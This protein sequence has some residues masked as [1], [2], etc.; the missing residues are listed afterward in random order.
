MYLTEIN[1]PLLAFWLTVFVDLI[2]A[3]PELA[4][5]LNSQVPPVAYVSQ[6]YNFVFSA[7]TFTS[8]APQISYTITHGP[9]WLDLDGPSRLIQGVPDSSDVGTTTLQLVASDP[10]GDLSA[11]ITLIV[12][13]SPTLTLG[14]PLLPQLEESGLIS[15]PSSLLAQPQ[16]PFHVSF[17]TQTFTGATPETRYYA[18]SAGNAPLPP[19]VHFDEDQLEFSGITPALVSSLAGSQTYGLRLIA[20]NVPGFAELAIDFQLVISRRILAFSAAT[21]IANIS[22]GT[23]FQTL[24][25]RPLI[26]LNGA[27]VT[28]DQIDS[29]DVDVPAWAELDR[30]GLSLSGTPDDSVSTTIT[31]T[32]TDIYHDVANA[33]IFL[34]N[35][36]SSSVSLGVIG[37]VN[38]TAGEYFS[39][40]WTSPTYSPWVRAVAILGNASA[41][42]DFNAQTWALSGSVPRDLPG[43]TLSVSITFANASTNATGDVII[44]VLQKPFATAT[45]PTHSTTSPT[46]S[47][48]SGTSKASE[49]A[50]S[51][52]HGNT[53]NNHLLHIVLA[54]VFSVGGVL[55]AVSLVL[56]CLRRRRKNRGSNIA[57]FEEGS[58]RADGHSQEPSSQSAQDAETIA[59]VPDNQHISPPNLST[60]NPAQSTECLENSRQGL[61]STKRPHPLTQHRTTQVFTPG[62]VVAPQPEAIEEFDR[63]A[64]PAFEFL[65]TNP[66]LSMP[67]APA[68]QSSSLAAGLQSQQRNSTITAQSSMMPSVVGLPDRKSGAGHGGG[69]L[70]PPDVNTDQ[71]SWR[72]TWASSLSNDCRRTTLVLDSFP[73]PPVDGAT[74]ART[75]VRTKSPVPFMRMVPEDSSQPLS[76][77]EQRQRWH[78]ERARARLEGSAR[79]SNAGSAR[80]LVSP[81]YKWAR[82]TAAL[83]KQNPQTPTPMAREFKA[84][85]A[86]D[87]PEPSWSMWSR[88]EHEVDESAQIGGFISSHNGNTP[89]LRKQR[90]I[91][92][93]GQFESIT[94]SDSYLEDKAPSAE[95]TE[96]DTQRGLANRGSQS[97]PRL[98]LN[99]ISH[100][101]ENVRSHKGA[102]KRSEEGRR[103]SF[104]FV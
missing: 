48:A 89:V 91:A 66:R 55:L 27:P 44:Q 9:K 77:E 16:Q 11:S 63:T 4:F 81:R 70:I 2:T 46:I 88:L 51:S 5:P 20:S 76:F 7:D 101:R 86:Q 59:H 67:W 36:G 22:T 85:D 23:R 64:S 82:N 33:T 58:D 78:T 19:W 104:R 31:I 69:I 52:P 47:R 26:T 56:C 38:V 29:I 25:L 35:T 72:N 39:Y 83:A 84:I 32:V 10:T 1:K 45:A 95:E 71:T 92:S 87:F 41:W 94:S 8:N 6:P 34:E 75:G 98:P 40:Y 30:N 50:M 13:E 54:C 90:S 100:S 57:S 15:P 12:L 102:M 73:A 3:A 43:Q 14:T 99:L 62:S 74:A 80:L 79:F 93:S 28:D 96:P 24:P 37:V 97:S 65:P 53:S 49:R 18:V 61:S 60:P 68:I 42:L 17:E 103:G 21:Q